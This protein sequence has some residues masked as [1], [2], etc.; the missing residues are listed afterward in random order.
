MLY[1]LSNPYERDKF[2]EYINTLYEEQACVEVKKRHPR[3][4]MAQNKY[5]HVLLAYFGAEFGYTLEQVKYD[6]F[7]R[8]CN[9]ELFVAR[10]A[11]KYGKE[12]E[13]VRSTTELDT[14]E[15]TAAIERFRNYSAAECGL[16][17]PEPRETEAL[18]FA[19]QAAEKVKEYL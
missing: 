9:T 15:L 14:A 3:R 19:E 12:V 17:L 7:K 5:L 1:N 11:N 18:F 10:H 6:I 16:Y 2:K 8:L 13:R 4:S